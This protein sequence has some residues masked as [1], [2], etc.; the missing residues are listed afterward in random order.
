[1]VAITD[2][3]HHCG[4]FLLKRKPTWS[5]TY[6]AMHV[7][8][9]T[10]FSPPFSSCRIQLTVCLCGDLLYCEAN[11]EVRTSIHAKPSRLMLLIRLAN[12]ENLFNLLLALV[13]PPAWLAALHA[14][15]LLLTSCLALDHFII[16]TFL[17]LNSLHVY[18]D[19]FGL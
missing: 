3:Q 15:L 17:H 9:R 11:P 14:G 8:P 13:G 4:L 18:L 2:Y 16:S 19:E 5:S 1:M 12:I 10:A 6:R 7:A